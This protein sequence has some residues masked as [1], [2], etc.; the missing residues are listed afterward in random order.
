MFVNTNMIYQRGKGSHAKIMTRTISMLYVNRITFHTRAVKQ[1]GGK[2][3]KIT[4]NCIACTVSLGL[5]YLHHVILYYNYALCKA[6]RLLEY[7]NPFRTS[8]ETHY[9]SVTESSQLMLCKI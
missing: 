5:S 6:C 8:Q 1:K 3:T 9:F 2:K 7:K 4:S